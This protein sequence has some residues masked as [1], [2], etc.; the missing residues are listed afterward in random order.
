MMWEHLVGLP[1]IPG[2]RDCYEIVRNFYFDNF[3]LELTNYARPHD[4]SSDNDDLIRRF[5]E[6][7]GF[8]MITDWRAEDLRPGDVLA[9]S[10]GDSNPNHLAV[11][12]G[13]NTI[14]HHLYG[15]F[16]TDEPYRDFIRNST[17][18]VLRHPAVPDLRP[19]FPDTTIASLL[20]ARH[21]LPAAD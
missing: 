10:I 8:R 13:D 14:V 4:W 9:L 5:Y 2:E 12:V 21:S 1:Y 6:R 7:E 19:V 15:R 17:S 16:S 3:G 18:F 20:N 11:F